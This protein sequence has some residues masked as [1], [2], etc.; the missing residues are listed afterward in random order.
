ML[1]SCCQ[2]ISWFMAFNV[3]YAIVNEIQNLFGIGT[4]SNLF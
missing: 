3:S 4:S 1:N 2:C